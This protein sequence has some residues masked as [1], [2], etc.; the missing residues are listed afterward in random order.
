MY[1]APQ[2]QNR[3]RGGLRLPPIVWLAILGGGIAFA[4]I[5]APSLLAQRVRRW[6]PSPKNW[7]AAGVFALVCFVAAVAIGG[8]TWV[9]TE[10][11]WYRDDMFDGLGLYIAP[12]LFIWAASAFTW[13]ELGWVGTLVGLFFAG[14]WGLKLIVFTPPDGTDFW[15]NMNCMLYGGA[16]AM[17]VVSP[18]L[19][20]FG[21]K[22][23]PPQPEPQMPY[24][25]GYGYGAYPQQPMQPMQQPMPYPQQGWDPRYPP[26]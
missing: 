20:W 17:A 12:V 13:V 23:P 11:R 5:L 21:R 4:I 2:T 24:P 6:F 7:V 8:D 22:I 18:A 14:I 19:A 26:R 15:P 25:Q 1:G 10:D 9:S 16:I 3:F